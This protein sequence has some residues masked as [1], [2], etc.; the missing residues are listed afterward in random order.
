MDER[1]K[2]LYSVRSILAKIVEQQNEFEKINEFNINN[3]SNWPMMDT[4]VKGSN[5]DGFGLIS[6]NTQRKLA[7]QQHS[8]QNNKVLTSR[9]PY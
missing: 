1:A 4:P 8:F 6:T 3:E 2:Y 9:T 7:S 5:N